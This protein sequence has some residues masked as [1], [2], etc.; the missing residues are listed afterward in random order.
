MIISTLAL[1]GLGCS[2]KTDD[3]GVTPALGTNWTEYTHLASEIEPMP[4]GLTMQALAMS[5]VVQ[6]PLDTDFTQLQMVV[7]LGIQFHQSTTFWIA[8]E[9]ALFNVQVT[10]TYTSE[11]QERITFVSS[12]LMV[13]ELFKSTTQNQTRG[14]QSWQTYQVGTFRLDANNRGVSE[15]L[16][17]SD[18]M[19]WA[20]RRFR[21]SQW[22]WM[23]EQH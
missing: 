9:L 19:Y 14:A 10:E 1:W 4:C 17:G 13:L 18:V 8:C 3:T 15:S 11:V 20:K 22:L 23:V 6:L 12:T 5:A 21:S 2:D 7:L 16:T